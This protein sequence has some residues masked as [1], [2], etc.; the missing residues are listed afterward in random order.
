MGGT[1]LRCEEVGSRWPVWRLGWVQGVA[2]LRPML[3]KCQ[4]LHLALSLNVVCPQT[5]DTEEFT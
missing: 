3:C 2:Y 5:R 1:A 4:L